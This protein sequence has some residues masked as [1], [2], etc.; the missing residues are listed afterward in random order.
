MEITTEELAMIGCATDAPYIIENTSQSQFSIARRYGGIF[1]N[2]YRYD[3]FRSTD[4]LVRRDVIEAVKKLRREAKKA[5]S[6]ALKNKQMSLF[7]DKQGLLSQECLGKIG[8]GTGN[9][10]I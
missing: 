10:K 6:E 8:E 7:G 9:G 2:N 3:Y 1:Y 5:R 4:L